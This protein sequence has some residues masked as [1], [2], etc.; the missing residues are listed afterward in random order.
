[1]LLVQIFFGASAISSMFEKLKWYMGV[2]LGGLEIDLERIFQNLRAFPQFLSEGKAFCGNCEWPVEFEPRLSDRSRQASALGEYFWQDLYVA[3]RVMALDPSR[4]VDVGSR[5]DGFVAHL[6][7]TRTLEVLD[8]RPLRASIQNVAFHRQDITN[9]SPEWIE[10]ADCV[11]CLHSIEHFGLGRYG[12]TIDPNSW[13]CGLANLATIVRRGGRLI[14]STPVG[15]QR[16][17][18]NSHRVFHPRTIYTAAACHNLSLSAFAFY[19]PNNPSEQA[20]VTTSPPEWDF[21]S[22]GAR[23]YSLGIFEFVKS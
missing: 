19:S 18:F 8:I 13:Q 14:L 17:K 9:L 4:H 15:I 12:D 16:V 5:I 23:K 2:V 10:Y 1:M 7:C 6:A 22:L 11:T 21:E 20:V 3:K